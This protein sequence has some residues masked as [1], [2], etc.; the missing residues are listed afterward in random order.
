MLHALID[1]A[2][3]AVCSKYIFN[4]RRAYIS[5]SH[6]EVTFYPKIWRVYILRL[7]QVVDLLLQKNRLQCR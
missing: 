1:I 3:A 7:L 2:E 6:T 5:Q 4:M